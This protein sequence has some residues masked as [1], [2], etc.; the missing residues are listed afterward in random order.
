MNKVIHFEIPA[1]NMSEA[2]KFYEEVFGWKMHKAMDEYT[3]A[4]TG[5][6][7]E[8]QMPAEPG[9]IN[10]AI[11]KKENDAPTPVLVVGVENIETALEKIK[12]HGGVV[13]M[14]TVK[15]FDMGMYARVKDPEG[16]IIGVWQDLKKE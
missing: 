3:I 6:A 14:P 4:I 5:P 13:V 1:A 16:N 7:N 8:Q 12:E 15:V 9:F 10:G 11:M 2:V